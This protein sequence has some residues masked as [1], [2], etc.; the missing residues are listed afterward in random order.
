MIFWGSGWSQASYFGLSF[1][2]AWK[3]D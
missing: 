3:H 2:W 1:L